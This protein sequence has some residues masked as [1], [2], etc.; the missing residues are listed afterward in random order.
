MRHRRPTLNFLA[1]MALLLVLASISFGQSPATTQTAVP[2]RPEKNTAAR[3][4]AKPS[5]VEPAKTTRTVTTRTSAASTAQTSSA[6][7]TAA[8]ASAPGA[9]TQSQ[10]TAHHLVV[11][12]PAGKSQATAHVTVSPVT[13]PSN[14]QDLFNQTVQ[15]I[16]FD[17]GTSDLRPDAVQVLAKLAQEIRSYPTWKVQI[18]GNTDPSEGSLTYCLALGERRADSAKQWLSQNGA[19]VDAMKTISY[20]NVKPICTDSTSNCRTKNRRVHFTLLSY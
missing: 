8:P 20:G 19:Y 2:V 18:E 9:R 7:S 4:Q 17:T 3:K 11:T 10:N 1:G 6:S 15:D 14:S 16:Y 5:R 13:S 12:G